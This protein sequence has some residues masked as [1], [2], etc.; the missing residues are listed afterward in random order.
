MLHTVADQLHDIGGAFSC[1]T[2]PVLDGAEGDASQALAK[3]GLSQA[4]AEADGFDLG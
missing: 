3:L 1:A 4:C 2:L